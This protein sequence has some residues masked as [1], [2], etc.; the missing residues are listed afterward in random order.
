MKLKIVSHD[1]IFNFL[2]WMQVKRILKIVSR[3]PFLFISL[4]GRKVTKV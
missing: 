3:D 1:P 4:D 2:F